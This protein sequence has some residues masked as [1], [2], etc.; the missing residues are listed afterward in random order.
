MQPERWRLIEEIFHAALESDPALRPAFLESACRGDT[1][2]R[3]QVE[4]LLQRDAESGEL[5]N[6]PIEQIADEVLETG[7]VEAEFPAGSMVGPYLIGDR[8]GAGGMG[9]VYRAQD[10]RLR[11]SVA[12]KT[13]R[14][15]FTDRFQREA[16]AISALNH[17]NICTLYDIGAQDGV[18]YLVMEYVEGQPVR[19][20]LKARE[21]LRLAIQIAGALE[22]AHEQSILHRDL[23]PA[24]ILLSKTG[25]KLLDFGLAKFVRS[26]PQP[27]EATATASITGAGQIV[28]TVAYM[29]PEQ[30][31]AKALDA[32]SDIF[33]FGLVLYEMLA[34][35]R[36]FEGTSQYGVM[37]AILKEQPAAL[38]SSVPGALVRALYKCLEKD[39]AKRWQTVAELRREL[40]RIGEA[41]TRR[42]VVP[43]IITA[44]AV[45]LLLCTASFL[46]W[47]NRPKLTAKDTIVIG[48]FEN[49][50]GDSV[51]DDTLRQG[52]AVQLEQSPFLS[53][54]SDERIHQIL[55]L[56]GRPADT[57]LTRDLAR[58]ICERTESAAVLDGSIAGR[59]SLYIVGLQARDCRSG[60]TL[61]NDQAKAGRKEE[62]LKALQQVASRFRTRAGESL[63]TV[64]QLQTWQEEATTPSLQAWKAYA[65]G[66]RVVLTQGNPAAGVPFFQHAV[67]IDPHFAAAYAALGRAYGDQWQPELSAA[68]MTKAY[69]ERARASERERFFIEGNYYVQV[70]G[71]L[72]RARDAS[73]LWK[74]TYLRDPHPA[75][76][77]SFIYQGLAQYPKALEEGRRTIE[78]G[79]DLFFGYNNLAWTYIQ[80]NQPE[81]AE[82]TIREA[83]TRKLSYAEF[84]IVRYSAD[85][86]KGDRAAMDREAAGSRGKPGE[87]DWI[88]ALEAATLGYSGHL[89][90]SRIQLSHAVDMDQQPGRRERGALYQAGG[91]VREAFFGSFSEARQQAA[92][93]RK[94]SD[95]RDAKYGAAMALALSG[96][97]P[98]S[99]AIAHQLAERFPEDTTAQYLYLPTLKAM[100]TLAR[101]PAKAIE[102]LRP[103]IPYDLAVSGASSGC[104]GNMYTAYARGLAYKAA[105]QGAE[106]AAEFQRILDNP[107]L[108]VNDPVGP[109]AQLELGRAW[110]VAGDNAKAKLAFEK[111][112]ALWKDADQD[113]PVLLQ[114]KK[115]YAAL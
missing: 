6:A 99:Q 55:G 18:G 86:L 44:A 33:S 9:Q 49:K 70:T 89:R 71:N 103:S 35:R 7:P 110:A 31:E 24:N 74:Q 13:L 41:L 80:L 51:F 69:L 3:S 59:D 45:T 56:M 50:T 85:F 12:I 109:V 34:G 100:A 23:K 66:W 1:E 76:L 115:E 104:F 61:D 46:Y 95:G 111:F 2:L 36:A 60:D 57:K 20:P 113:I 4:A 48:D 105:H 5:L 92:A 53:L 40:E 112:L 73:E 68:S 30:I 101:D 77:L 16:R 8:L 84:A 64:K 26:K 22:A 42:A 82:E 87:E 65:T 10:T 25:V 19:G 90:Q 15:R 91:A 98:G 63:T 27:D 32:R 83:E 14:A 93:A 97:I 43:W 106:A 62:V 58:E 54:V 79:P 38:P 72:E 96:D 102:A 17:P 114:A 28:G 37:A 81:K 29:S 21:A 78:R 108:R 88:S 52:L 39:P 75:G 47:S 107:G 11:R 94:L 67:E